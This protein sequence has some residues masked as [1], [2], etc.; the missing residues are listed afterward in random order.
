MKNWECSIRLE[1]VDDD[2]NPLNEVRE[3]MSN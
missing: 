3:K 2:G 1:F